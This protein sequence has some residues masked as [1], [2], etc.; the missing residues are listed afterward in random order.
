MRTFLST[1]L[2]MRHAPSTADPDVQGWGMAVAHL[3]DAR[4]AY[5]GDRAEGLRRLKHLYVETSDL[6]LRD[7][8]LGLL[9][10]DAV[11]TWPADYRGW[12]LGRL[13]PV[14]LHASREH[15]VP[16]SVSIAQAVLESGWGR[17]KLTQ[18][19][20]NLF[21]VKAGASVR[22]VMMDTREHIGGKLRPSQ[23]IFRTYGGFDESIKHHA[24]LLSTDRRYAGARQVWTDWEEFLE[25]I[26]PRYASD[27]SYPRRVRAIVELYSLDRWDEMIVNAV[28]HDRQVQTRRAGD[29]A[30][31]ESAAAGAEG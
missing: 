3:A 8:I 15:Q 18:E 6:D 25:T 27:P 23:Q 29:I 13:V 31:R 20:H 22:R 9:V 14:V 26:S 19:H 30:S 17:S 21:G 16:P 4:E 2:P 7:H 12:F 24:A 28:L 5:R 10:A 11:E 1:A